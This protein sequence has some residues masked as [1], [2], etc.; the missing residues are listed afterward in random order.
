MFC[1]SAIRTPRT[2]GIW[3]PLP[4]FDTVRQDGQ[5]GNIK[6]TQRLFAALAPGTPA[7]RVLGD[8]QRRGQR[9]P[10]LEHRVGQAYVTRVINAIMRSPDWSLDRDLADLG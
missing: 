3:N 7:R 8:S 5:L 1:G 9:A 4:S 10:D 6:D 2:P